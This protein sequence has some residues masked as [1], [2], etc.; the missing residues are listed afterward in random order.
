VRD[1]ES[2]GRVVE[3]ALKTNKSLGWEQGGTCG[4]SADADMSARGDGGGSF[5]S[6]A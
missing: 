4:A 3:M 5:Q 6:A 2:R 1:R